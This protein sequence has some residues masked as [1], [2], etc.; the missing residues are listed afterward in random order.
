MIKEIPILFSTPMVQAILAGRK[1]MT[2]RIIKPQP[3]TDV[4]YMANEPLDWIGQW[5][6]WKWDTEEGESISKH[7]P[8]GQIGDLLW[9]REAWANCYNLLTNPFET[10]FLYKADGTANVHRWKPSIHMP[11]AAA[12]IWLEVTNIRV[13][14]LQDIS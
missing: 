9:V 13:E 7:C 11:K 3:G 4:S 14:R 10:F 8:F 6:P 2:R 12:R 1:T 5:Y